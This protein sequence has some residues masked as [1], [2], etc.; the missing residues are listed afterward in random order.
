M[1]Q[2]GVDVTDEGMMGEYRLTSSLERGL[3]ILKRAALQGHRRAM[4]AYASHFITA[5][6]VEM[7][8]LMWLSQIDTAAEGLM[9]HL[10][11]VHL[12]GETPEGEEAVYRVLLDPSVPFP[13]DYFDHVTGSMTWMFQMLTPW[14]V[15]WA[16]Q[17][18]Y[19]LR[20]CWTP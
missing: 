20:D 14:G 1:Y 8:S 13:D 11:L 16:R 15:D 5:G 19:A 10:L 18:A 12:S 9:W 6:I 2:L 17:Q 4:E 7:T 3:P